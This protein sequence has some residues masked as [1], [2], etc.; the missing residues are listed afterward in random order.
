MYCNPS[1]RQKLPFPFLGE[2]PSSRFQLDD[3]GRFLFYGREKFQ[4]LYAAV[5]GMRF[6]RTRM[7]FLHGTLGSGKSFM[8]AALACLL[9]KEGSKVVFVPDCRALLRDMF[10]YLRLALRL[11]FHGPRHEARTD[12]LDRSTT[13]EELERFCAAAA[14]KYRLLF[15]IDQA[16]ALDSE[17][18][19][20]DRFTRQAKREARALLDKITAQHLKLASSSSNYQHGPY[21]RYRQAGEKRLQLYGGLTEV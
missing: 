14:S 18:E 20:V 2:I 6:Q 13:V 1:H 3:K 17:E 10:G 5:K 4:E 8:L 19:A 16:N 12:F 15:I 7:C 21:D 11:A 9:M